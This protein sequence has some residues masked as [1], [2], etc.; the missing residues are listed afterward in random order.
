EHAFQ[1]L[2]VLRDFYE[3]RLK[4]S[5]KETE[6]LRAVTGENGM[7]VWARLGASPDTNFAG[8]KTSAE[9]EI[10]FWAYRA[11]DRIYRDAAAQSAASI[12]QRSCERI[13]HQIVQAEAALQTV[14]GG[15]A[16]A[17]A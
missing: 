3:G 10:R 15:Y 1:E 2:R 17:S 16:E 5:G 6:K 8:L 14:A 9:D 4:L 12:L 7:N 11:N 13:R